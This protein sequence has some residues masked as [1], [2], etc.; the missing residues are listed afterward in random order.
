MRQY[1]PGDD[2]R[3]I[4][5]RGFL[6][7]GQLLVQE[8]EQGIT[9]KVVILLDQ[10]RRQHSKGL[11]SESFEAGVRAVASLGVHHL[12]RATRSPSRATP[13]RIVGPLRSGPAKL[14]LLDELARL[15]LG[16]RAAHRRA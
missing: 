10:D 4:V 13:A 7:T 1:A 6:R 16:A 3:R 15:D 2:V 5:W 14:R 12:A 8:A 11:V 9:D